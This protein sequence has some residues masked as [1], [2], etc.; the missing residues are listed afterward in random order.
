[1]IKT[2]A[3]IA[4]PSGLHTRPAS[5]ISK[6][7]K[8]FAC[9]IT[10]ATGEKTADAKSMVQLLKLAMNQGDKVDVICD[11]ENEAAASAELTNFLNTYVE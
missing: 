8:P 2:T 9:T 11:G 7:A 5:A 6:L 3:T 1:M 4:N 10:L